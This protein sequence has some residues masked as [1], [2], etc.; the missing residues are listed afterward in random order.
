[1][2]KTGYTPS[3][4]R[5]LTAEMLTLNAKRNAPSLPQNEAKLLIKINQHIPADV[6]NRYD[7]LIT[8][9]D[10]ETLTSDEYLELLDLTKKLKHLTISVWK[11]W[12]N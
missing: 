7:E 3:E 4:L 12:P 9:R 1:V 2:R 6:Q 11:P 10:A 8:R 5:Q